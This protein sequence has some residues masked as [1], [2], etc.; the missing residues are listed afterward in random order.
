MHAVD[1]DPQGAYA[2]ISLVSQQ[3]EGNG[4]TVILEWIQE[5]SLYSYHVNITPQ[6]AVMF[7]ESTRVQLTVLYNVLYNFSV[8]A[9]NQCGQQNVTSFTELYYSERH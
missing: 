6:L 3:F 9:V 8:A 2:N 7:I 5:M 4:I 1:L